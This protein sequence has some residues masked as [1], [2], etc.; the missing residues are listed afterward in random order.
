MQPAKPGR[1]GPEWTLPHLWGALEVAYGPRM[2]DLTAGAARGA[3]FVLDTSGTAAIC[4]RLNKL[5]SSRVRSAIGEVEAGLDYCHGVGL[6]PRLVIAGYGRGRNTERPDLCIVE[7]LVADG[8]ANNLVWS[9]LEQV[10]R[11]AHPLQ[12]HLARIEQMHA[13]LH[14]VGL[15]RALDFSADK[16][17]IDV[18]IK[19]T[20][21]A[22]D[23]RRRRV[24]ATGSRRPMPA[25]F[26]FR[27]LSEGPSSPG[28]LAVDPEQWLVVRE[29]FARYLTTSSLAEL[30]AEL[31]AC[32]GVRVP[33]KKLR[34]VLGNAAYVDGRVIDT[35]DGVS[36]VCVV[37]LDDPVP[38]H[39]YRSVQELLAQRSR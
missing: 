2:R 7:D 6:R 4:V 39:L 12:E 32:T 21:A 35:V 24:A 18:A 31:L 8:V 33:E 25:P 26:G 3:A 16:L 29:A 37:E 5:S 19:R 30:A 11:D 27:R 15:G 38:Q 23:T 17:L 13:R 36:G 22:A 20:K 28:R 9:C 10:S 34:T 14:L 1:N